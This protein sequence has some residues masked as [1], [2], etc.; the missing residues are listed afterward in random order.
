MLFN[1]FRL[2]LKQRFALCREVGEECISEDDLMRV[3]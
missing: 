1:E 2:N 3:L